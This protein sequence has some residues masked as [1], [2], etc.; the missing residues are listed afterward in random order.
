[1][2]YV[3]EVDVDREG[4]AEMILDENAIAQV[5]R[6]CCFSSY[7]SE[8]PSGGGNLVFIR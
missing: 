5:P 1:M 6:E 7:G 2:V 3:D 4:I 8:A